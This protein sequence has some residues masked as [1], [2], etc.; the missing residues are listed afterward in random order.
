MNY[1][2]S[3]K[4]HASHQDGRISLDR[5]AEL[6]AVLMEIARDA[7]Q[8]RTRGFSK[9]RGKRPA[10]VIEG[11]KIELVGLRKGSTV[12]ALE[13]P[14]ILA[15]LP[16]GVQLDLEHPEWEQL[17]RE[18]TGMSLVIGSFQQAL[19]GGEAEFLD[20]PLLKDMRKLKRVLKSPQESIVLGN[21]SLETTVSLNQQDFERINLLE[22]QTP[23]PKRVMVVGKLDLLEHSRSRVKVLLS[24]GGTA[25]GFLTEELREGNVKDYWGKE[26]ALTG[27]AYFRPNGKLAHLLIDQ[28][29]ASKPG[30]DLFRV[31]PKAE[32]VDQQIERQI[33]EGKRQDH[34]RRLVGQWPGEETYEEL[35]KLLRK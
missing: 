29:S 28:V 13:A 2:V 34:P 22:E 6:S 24:D 12:L 21:G 8:I 11:I 4:G 1:E 5:L 35:H 7:M 33:K 20:K 18:E 19:T 15:Q 10:E 16:A 26:L 32:T 3:I 31:V 23:A 25:T 27:T 14:P 30:D 17:Y 9:S